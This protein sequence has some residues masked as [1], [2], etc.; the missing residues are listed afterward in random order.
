MK[1]SSLFFHLRLI[2]IGLSILIPVNGFATYPS[3]PTADIS[4][5]GGTSGVADIQGAFNNARTTEDIQLGTSTTS[6]TL[7][8]QSEWDSMS[9]GERALWLINRERIDR[10]VHPLHGLEINVTGVAQYYAQYLL[11]T[12]QFSHNADGYDPW[13][14]LNQN[15]AI[16]S[17]HDFLSMAENLAY[18]A[19]TLSNIPLPIEQA[20]YTW[21]YDDGPSSWGHRHAIL[22]YPYNDN[23]GTAGM[24]G[25][26]GIGRANG[27]PYQGGWPFAEIIVMNVFDPCAT[28]NYATY[29]D[30]VGKCC[31]NP[32]PCP[33][34]IQSTINGASP[35][36]LIVV[37]GAVY[38]E[39]IIIDEEVTILP[40]PS[41]CSPGPV[42]LMGP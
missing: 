15:P 13:S 36:A 6:L 1:T 34:T 24:E 35:G 31:G 28:W 38:N 39:N 18:F 19:T 16:N 14:R 10:G 7:P 22:W 42:V 17:C 25:F 21:M 12:D 37:A 30:P 29:V 11:D 23:S 5:T 40:A 33:S 8:S 20:V 32:A 9:D 4:W 2:L 41:I 26:L 3:D 27:G